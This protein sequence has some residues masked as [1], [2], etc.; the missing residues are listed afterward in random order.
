MGWVRDGVGVRVAP[1]RSS[2]LLFVFQYYPFEISDEL[3][4]ELQANWTWGYVML[5]WHMYACWFTTSVR[6]PI[7]TEGRTTRHVRRVQSTR[8][9]FCL[10]VYRMTQKPES[11]VTETDKNAEKVKRRVRDVQWVLLTNLLLSLRVKEFCQTV[12]GRI[13]GV[14]FSREKS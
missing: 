11:L 7:I 8:H 10:V 3:F 5:W 13:A 6:S 9:L 4:V 2:S 12:K 14:D 1:F